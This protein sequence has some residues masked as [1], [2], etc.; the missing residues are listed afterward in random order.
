M[1]TFEQQPHDRAIQGCSG[2]NVL[3]L[4]LLAM[5]PAFAAVAITACH[6]FG[7]YMLMQRSRCLSPKTSMR[8]HKSKIT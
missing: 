3:S 5:G 7:F 1:C 6:A 2:S 4:S 8:L